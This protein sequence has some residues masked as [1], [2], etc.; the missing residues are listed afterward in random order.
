MIKKLLLLIFIISAIIGSYIVYPYYKVYNASNI[1]N[2]AFDDDEQILILSDS[3]SFTK[4]GRYL[5]DN[6]IIKDSISFNILINY[7][8][9]YSN[10]IIKAGEFT[11]KRDW[12]NNKLV[13]QLYLMRNQSV[14]TIVIPQ[15]R[16]IEEISTI[17]SE[18]LNIDSLRFIELLHDREIYSKYGFSESTFSTMFL[19]NTYEVY[20]TI[21]DLELIDFFAKEYKK[22]WNKHRVAKSKLLNLSQSEITILASIVLQEQQLK[23]DEHSK[24][25]GLYINRLNRNI[26]LQADPT[27]KFALNRPD[28]KRVLLR[29]LEVESPYN[30]YLN[31]GL[32]PGPIC[33]PNDKVIDAVLNYE[34]H[35]FIFMCAMPEFSGY[36]NFAKTNS[37]HNKN[38]S[39]YTSWLSEKGIR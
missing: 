29:H 16:Y 27:V 17:I 32:P 21:S 26:K 15:M 6:K 18:Q 31:E 28:I 9:G 36:H 38:R 2:M 8:K 23:Y 33:I 5:Q 25:A 13:N 30:T 11:I 24:I 10:A 37:E 4:L 3:L 39:K 20:S 1:D 34:K 22:F 7:K 19:P 14:I 12:N 35:D